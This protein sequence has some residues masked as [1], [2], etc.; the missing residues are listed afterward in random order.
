MTN[1]IPVDVPVAPAAPVV[2]HTLPADSTA[3]LAFLDVI[4]LTLQN[5]DDTNNASV[6]VIFT[7]VSGPVITQTYLIQPLEA[8]NVIDEDAFGGPQSGLGGATISLSLAGST[9]A[10][11]WGWFFRSRG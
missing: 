1:G 4:S 6:S 11:A 8:V 5:T 3:G 10:R 7:P 9:A 2:I